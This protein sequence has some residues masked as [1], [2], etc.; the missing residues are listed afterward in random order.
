MCT[1]CF[2]QDFPRFDSWQAFAAF[3]HA[4]QLRGL[5][6]C[7]RPGN[8]P[9]RELFVLRDP[10]EFRQCATC[11]QVWALSTPDNAWRGYFLP[12]DRA[13]AQLHQVPSLP[14]GGVVALAAGLLLL[15]GL[16]GWWG[17]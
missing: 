3:E 10:H 7:A 13:L 17:W 1:A 9:A 8:W 4:L 14:W 2:E 16:L 12:E 15:L 6:W 5:V 11:G